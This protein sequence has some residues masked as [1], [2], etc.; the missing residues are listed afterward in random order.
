MALVLFVVH[1]VALQKHR[2][3]W[4]LECSV[5]CPSCQCWA[6][7]IPVPATRLSA[8]VQFLSIPDTGNLFCLLTFMDLALCRV[9]VSTLSYAFSKISP[10]IFIDPSQICQDFPTDIS[11]ICP[12]ISEFLRIRPLSLQGSTSMMGVCHLLFRGWIT[13]W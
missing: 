4:H 1:R 9:D 11:S 12:F 3:Q 5:L 8:T 7:T 13:A 10:C 6:R 2:L